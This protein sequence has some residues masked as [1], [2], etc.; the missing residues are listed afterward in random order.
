MTFTKIFEAGHYEN[1][2]VNPQSSALSHVDYPL[3]AYKGFGEHTNRLFIANLAKNEPQISVNLGE[4]FQI[5]SFLDIG[6]QQ[7]TPF[8]NLSLTQI[9]MLVR[10]EQEQESKNHRYKIICFEMDPWKKDPKMKLK[11]VLNSFRMDLPQS[12]QEC[13]LIAHNRVS[14]ASRQFLMKPDLWS[15]PKEF[16]QYIIFREHIDPR[17][18]RIVMSLISRFGRKLIQDEKIT[19]EERKAMMEACGQPKVDFIMFL[20]CRKNL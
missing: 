10:S 3:L 19:M 13:H 12:E 4:H 9:Y 6:T 14:F 11:V 5:M 8:Q 7:P 18:T 1:L 15:D 20:R 2:P 16:R 17:L